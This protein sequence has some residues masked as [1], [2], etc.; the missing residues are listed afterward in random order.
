MASAETL[1]ELSLF[2]LGLPFEPN[3]PKV[4]PR[5]AGWQSGDLKP[6]RYIEREEITLGYTGCKGRAAK[7]VCLVQCPEGP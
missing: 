2:F 3:L 1:A 6:W 5:E 4:Y 7:L